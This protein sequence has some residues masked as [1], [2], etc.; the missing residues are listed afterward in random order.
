MQPDAVRRGVRVRYRRTGERVDDLLDHAGEVGLVILHPGDLQEEILARRR[1]ALAQRGFEH[2]VVVLVHAEDEVTD[3]VAVEV[4]A[5]E[6]VGPQGA[7]LPAVGQSIAVGVDGDI[8]AVGAG[9]RNGNRGGATRRAACPK[10]DLESENLVREGVLGPH[11]VLALRRESYWIALEILGSGSGRRE[12]SDHGGGIRFV[13]LVNLDVAIAGKENAVTSDRNTAVRAVRW[14]LKACLG[15]AGGRT[16]WI[17]PIESTAHVGT[18]VDLLVHGV[19][20]HAV[21][22]VQARLSVEEERRRAVG[23][24]VEDAYVDGIEGVRPVQVVAA[25]ENVTF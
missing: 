19:P 15:R 4:D 14:H 25:P 13:H 11:G 5:G 22:D 7:L 3:T 17:E 20:G 8:G 16:R 18:L 10:R 12:R 24:G 21:A 6:P 23:D 1:R 9:R 2:A